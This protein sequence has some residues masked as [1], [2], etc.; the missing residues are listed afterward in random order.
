MQQKIDYKEN[1]FVFC[2]A[3][4]TLV[5]YLRDQGYNAEAL[6]GGRIQEQRQAALKRFHDG[7]VDILVCTDVASRGIDVKGVNAVIN[8]DMTA[9]IDGKYFQILILSSKKN[10]N[11]V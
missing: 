3:C 5:R 9:G 6:H 7:A 11:V 10:L 4:E 2:E 8:Y 1:Y